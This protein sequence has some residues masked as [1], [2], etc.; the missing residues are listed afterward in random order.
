MSV[1]LLTPVDV[2]YVFQAV[3]LLLYVYLEPTY[4]PLRKS[5][6][7]IGEAICRSSALDHKV[8]R[9]LVRSMSLDVLARSIDSG[10]L[11][12]GGLEECLHWVF[13]FSSMIL[14]DKEISWLDDSVLDCSTGVWVSMVICS[15]CSV[16]VS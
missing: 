6:E 9:S 7:W 3:S 5:L 11:V 13:T 10:E 16:L 8:L 14:L 4:F 2:L 15:M 12:S 1:T